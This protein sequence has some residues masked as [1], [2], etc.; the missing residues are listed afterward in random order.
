MKLEM[1]LQASG[2]QKRTNQID[3][4]SSRV[5]PRLQAWRRFRRHKLALVGVGIVAI[6]TMCAILAPFITPYSPNEVNLKEKERPPSAAHL[7]G[8][9][10]TGRDVLARVLYGARVSL[11]VGL[12]SACLVTA[13]GTLLGAL[14]GYYGGI[15]DSVLSRITETFM[16]F[17]TLIIVTILVAMLG[18]GIQNAILAIGL[19]WW[20][21]LARLV[22]GQFLS[23]REMDYVEAARACGVG[24]G[25]IIQRHILPNAVGPILVQL[26]FLVTSAI[27]IE[28]SL[29]FLGLGVKIP[30]PS[31]GGMLFQAQTP[32]ILEQVP[33]V[34]LPPGIMIVI[35]ALSIN[36]IGDALRD[37]LDPRI[38]I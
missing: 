29:S 19:F 25:R 18:P 31:W 2:K 13:I 27:I 38:I 23:L 22:R 30:T 34:W 33:W 26:T 20:P 6:L 10:Q 28:A 14:M 16:C 11:L 3:I 9:D 35:T 4:A 12:A 17:P 24:S 36:F 37:A 15:V 8:T 32:R 1:S 5:T 7:L 21:S